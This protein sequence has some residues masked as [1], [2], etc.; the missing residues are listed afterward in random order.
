MAGYDKLISWVK[1]PFRLPYLA[2]R[3]RFTSERGYM[4][5]RY[6]REFGRAVDLENPRTFNE[7]IQYLK[8]YHR[9]AVLPALVDKYEV[10]DHVARRGCGWALNELLGVYRRVEEID[11]QALAEPF[12]LKMTNASGR[13]NICTDKSKLDWGRE[14]KTIHRWSKYNYYVEGREWVYRSIPSRIVIE[15]YLSDL[16]NPSP[17]DYKILCFEGVP[18]YIGVDMERRTAH[19]RNLF[20]LDW[21]LLPYQYGFPRSSRTI[22]RPANLGE[23]IEVAKILARGLFFCRVD[24]YSILGRTVFGEMT[25]IPCNG[26]GHFLPAEHDLEWGSRMNLANLKNYP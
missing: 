25:F 20:D 18:H 3:A 19:K 12:V 4:E 9:P 7:K 8:L 1:E 10:R 11:F 6:L 24:L 16:E 2:A 5:Q 23:M 14:V 22:A 26:F 15:K 21:N 13:N 17:L